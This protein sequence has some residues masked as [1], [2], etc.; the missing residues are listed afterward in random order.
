MAYSGETLLLLIWLR[1][2]HPYQPR[3]GSTL[4][5]ASGAAVSGAALGALLGYIL[6]PGSSALMS[7]AQ[8]ALILAICSLQIIPWMLPEI[9]DLLQI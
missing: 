3:L 5:R 2:R 9:K 8:A 1:R 6:G 4:L 7:A